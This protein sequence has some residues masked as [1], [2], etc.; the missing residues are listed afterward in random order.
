MGH[1]N[2][3]FPVPAV[4]ILAFLNSIQYKNQK[5]LS[6]KKQKTNKDLD[7]VEEPAKQGAIIFKPVYTC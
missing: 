5:P 1:F 4:L 2:P 6:K 7:I 3:E